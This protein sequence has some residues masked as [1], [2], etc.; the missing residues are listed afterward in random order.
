MSPSHPAHGVIPVAM[1]T[2]IQCP[3]SAQRRVLGLNAV[4]LL[5]P[6]LRGR[7]R[8]RWLSRRLNARNRKRGDC[9]SGLT[10]H[11]LCFAA[12]AIARLPSRGRLSASFALSQGGGALAPNKTYPH[13]PHLA[14]PPLT[15]SRADDGRPPKHIV[16][17]WLR[18]GWK[19]VSDPGKACRTR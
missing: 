11:R 19:R 15:N 17:N 3:L 16:G 4:R 13:P 6:P 2:G 1:Q 10:P 12:L 8:F 9:S 18:S 7:K 14:Y 5:S